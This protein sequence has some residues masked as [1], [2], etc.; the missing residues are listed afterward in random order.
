MGRTDIGNI[1]P[2][3]GPKYKGA[4]YL[5]MKGRYLYQAFANYMGDQ[6]IMDGANYVASKYPWISAGFLWKYH[7]MNDLCDKGISLEKVTSIISGDFHGYNSI[8]HYYN[9]ARTV[10]KILLL[11]FYTNSFCLLNLLKNKTFF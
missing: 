10:F 1:F 6:K 5:Q 2:D 9:I 4:G 3:D 8:K 7:K 11:K